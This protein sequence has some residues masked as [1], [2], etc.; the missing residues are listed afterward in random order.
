MPKSLFKNISEPLHILINNGKM[1]ESMEDKANLRDVEPET[2][3]SFIEWCYTGNYGAPVKDHNEVGEHGYPSP[4]KIHNG[5]EDVKP[6]ISCFC[7]FVEDGSYTFALRG[8]RF[9]CSNCGGVLA[10]CRESRQGSRHSRHRTEWRPPFSGTLSVLTNNAI[11]AVHV[12]DSFKARQF[13]AGVMRHS[14]LRAQHKTMKPRDGPS[15]HLVLHARLWTFADER[16]ATSLKGLCLHKLHRDLI[17]YDLTPEH[18]SD[19]VDLIAYTFSGE[20]EQA[21]ELRNLVA[22]Y[23]ACKVEILMET[24]GFQELL[25]GGGLF[26]TAL[27]RMTIQRII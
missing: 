27:M 25:S 14:E 8:A 15:N 24:N 13:D 20:E 19:V 22:E 21:Q 2:F 18:S 11:R 3:V 5:D 26:M 17:A 23:A 16:L 10:V 9:V 4:G 12:W 6:Y 7:W 1:Q